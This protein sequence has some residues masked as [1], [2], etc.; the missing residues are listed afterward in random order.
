MALMAHKYNIIFNRETTTEKMGFEGWFEWWRGL[1]LAKLKRKIVPKC[2]SSI[3]ERTVTPGMCVCGGGGG[4]QSIVVKVQ[5]KDFLLVGTWWCHEYSP[6]VKC[7]KVNE[8]QEGEP[9]RRCVL[10]WGANEETLVLGLY[11]YV[12]VVRLDKVTRRAEAFL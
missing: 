5:S 12:W 4:G 1:L 9:W 8:K 7:H 6:E 3:G 10:W 11:M 2:R